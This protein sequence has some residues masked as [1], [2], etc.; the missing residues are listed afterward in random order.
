MPR[1]RS[2]G[3]DIIKRFTFFFPCCLYLYCLISCKIFLTWPLLI[4]REPNVKMY[5]KNEKKNLSGRFNFANWLPKDFSRGFNFA[6]LVKIR[7]NREN[8]SREQFPSLR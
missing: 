3:A 4:D 8:L 6:N 7:E 2:K 5:V 1:G